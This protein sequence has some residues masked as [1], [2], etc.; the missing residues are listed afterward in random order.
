MRECVR[1]LISPFDADIEV[2]II[3]SSVLKERVKRSGKHGGENCIILS[4]IMV[5]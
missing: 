2:V 3:D 4:S 1:D 5:F